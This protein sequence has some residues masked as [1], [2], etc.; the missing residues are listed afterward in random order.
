M[1]QEGFAFTV[2]VWPFF[3][4][5]YWLLRYGA[6]GHG[7]TGKRILAFVVGALLNVLVLGL[8][9]YSPIDAVIAEPMVMGGPEVGAAALEKGILEAGALGKSL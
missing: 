1:Y 5:P 9:G 3:L 2:L 4:L 8:V 6:W 7:S